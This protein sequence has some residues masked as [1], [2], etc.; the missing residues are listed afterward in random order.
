MKLLMLG[1]CM[2]SA[3][4]VAGAPKVD[5]PR[6]PS[7]FEALPFVETPAAGGQY[8]DTKYRPS[9]ND[10][11]DTKVSF[12][13]LNRRTAV[14]SSR[15]RNPMDCTMTCAV[16]EGVFRFD[17][18]MQSKTQGAKGMVPPK[19]AKIVKD[20]EYE[21]SVNF[22]S[23]VATVDGDDVGYYM[24]PGDF[25]TKSDLLLFALAC[26]GQKPEREAC[27]KSMRMF[28]FSVEDE[29]GK[30]MMELV[31]AKRKKDGANGFYD[32]VRK[33][34]LPFEKVAADAKKKGK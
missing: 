27:A 4:T 25:K 6:L 5:K 16:F 29:S 21:I 2:L 22:Q 30:K 31:P 20:R 28:G 23:C 18:N 34:F 3:A 1:V 19:S 13:K 15:G 24:P 9:C 14:F 8:V 17:R 33:M 11:F 10:K 12:T 26:N 32:T 7:G